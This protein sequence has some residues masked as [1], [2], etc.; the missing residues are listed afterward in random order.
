MQFSIYK[1]NN[2]R[3]RAKKVG[4]E[5]EKIKAANGGKINMKDEYALDQ[6]DAITGI[7]EECSNY[8]TKC[9]LRMRPTLWKYDPKDETTHMSNKKLFAYGHLV[10]LL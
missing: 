4:L 8:M 10:H 3:L 9:G 6:L 1:W 7:L 5:I 2:F